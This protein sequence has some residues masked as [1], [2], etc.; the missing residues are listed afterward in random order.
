MLWLKQNKSEDILDNDRYNPFI[1]DFNFIL[2]IKER[3]PYF[4][5]KEIK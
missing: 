3:N 5:K 4:R 2:K 1:D